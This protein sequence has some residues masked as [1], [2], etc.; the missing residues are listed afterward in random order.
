[1]SYLRG[2]NYIWTDGDDRLHIWASDG[3]DGS[4]ESVWAVDATGQRRA[5]RKNAGGVA[6]PNS[7]MDEYVMMRL[8]Q[9]I[10]SGAVHN[11][12]ERAVRQGNFGGT[13]L[14]A[15]AEAIRNA[16]REL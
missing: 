1:M 16:L 4:S 13:A 3:A 12:I 14:T 15:R 6:I 10:E 5:A 2:D 11:T 9:L 8:A 7:V